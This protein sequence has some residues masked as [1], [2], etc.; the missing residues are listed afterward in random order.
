MRIQPDFISI[1]AVFE[2]RHFIFEIPKY[3]RGYAW[4]DEQVEDF[5]NDLEKLVELEKKPWQAGDHFFG[6]ILCSQEDVTGTIKKNIIVDGQQRIATTVLL[7]ARLIWKYKEMAKRKGAPR[8]DIAKRREDIRNQYL[9]F[10]NRR[11][12][13]E[14]HLPR[15]TL[16][17]YDKEFFKVLTEAEDALPSPTR[18]SHRRLLS[19]VETIDKF[20]SQLT[21]CGSTKKRI[22]TLVTVEKIL[23]ER[24]FIVLLATD[25]VPDAYRLFQVLNDRGLVLNEA[26]LLRA[27]T[28]GFLD[29]VSSQLELEKAEAIWDEI[30]TD[31]HGDTQ[32]NLRWYFAAKTGKTAGKGSLYDEFCAAFFG[33]VS[34]RAF[35]PAKLVIQLEDLKLAVEKLRR[36]SDGKLHSPGNTQSRLW[37]EAKLRML[38]RILA[39]KHAM[40][41]LLAGTV[42]SDKEFEE[43]IDITARFFFRYKVVCGQHVSPMSKVYLKHALLLSTQRNKFRMGKYRGDLAALLASK[44]DDTRFSDDLKTLRYEDEGGNR[45][46]KYLL[47]ALEEHWPWIL[48]GATAND[49]GLDKTRPFDFD[50]A[51]IEHVYP[52]SVSAGHKDATLEALK[53]NLGNLSLL[54]AEDNSDVGNAPFATKRTS[55]VASSLRMNQT[56]GAL[57]VWDSATVNRRGN[58]LIQAAIKVFSL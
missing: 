37:R 21:E 19:A 57:T 33:G 27:Y 45:E 49:R 7:A 8:D 12:M 13:E 16:S 29:T 35:C 56:I 30:Q 11:N 38:V 25:K 4:D 52:K 46:L 55:L 3:Q 51:T 39:H 20:L 2:Q 44:A 28:L 22:E 9:V 50:A 31:P 40:P 23:N 58:E 24:C 26:D 54:A 14:R 36:L 17:R 47:V 18:E 42:L 5:C 32:D 53:N 1:G 41:L 48:N 10:R 15:L 34:R 43:L 6:G